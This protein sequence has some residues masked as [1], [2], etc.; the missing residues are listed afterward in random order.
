MSKLL[1]VDVGGANLSNIQVTSSETLQGPLCNMQVCLTA[2][3]VV[4]GCAAT[5]NVAVTATVAATVAVADYADADAC[6]ANG[7]AASTPDIACSDAEYNV[8]AVTTGVKTTHS[9]ESLCPMLWLSFWHHVWCSRAA[10]LLPAR[11]LIYCH[12]LN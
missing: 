10:L 1:Q 5:A 7:A 2:T 8:C 12:V 3:N 6:A 9:C 4:D 11:T